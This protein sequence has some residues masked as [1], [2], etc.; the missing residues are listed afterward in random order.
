MSSPERQE[1]DQQPYAQAVMSLAN[2]EMIELNRPKRIDPEDVEDIREWLL[3]LMRG[4]DRS[5]RNV[6]CAEPADVKADGEPNHNAPS[7]AQ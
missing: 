5:A 1:P 2:G 3:L 7:Q 4:I 6:P